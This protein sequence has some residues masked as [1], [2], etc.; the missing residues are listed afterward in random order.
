MRSL[1]PPVIARRLWQILAGYGLIVTVIYAVLSSSTVAT[2]GFLS[3][4]VLTVAACFSGPRTWGAEPPAAW[5]LIGSAASLFL[6]GLLIRPVVTDYAMPWPLLADLC[7]FSGYV[8]IGSF[9]IVMLRRRESTERHAVLDGLIAMLSTGLT[10]VLLLAL[11]AAAITGR[12][13]VVSIVQACYPICDVV[14]AMLV[15]NL[16]FTTRTWPVS[17]VA[18]LTVMVGMFTGDTL[19]AIAG[20]GGKIYASPLLDLPYLVAYTALGISAIHPSVVEIS[21]AARPPVQAWSGWRMALLIPAMMTPFLLMLSHSAEPFRHRVLL[22]A[23]G[24]VM[25]VLLVLRAV[26]AVQAQVEAQLHSEH[27]ASHDPLTSLPNRQA[28]S[29]AIEQVVLSVDPLGPDRVWVYM[30]DLDGFKWVND[31]WGHD[32]GDQLVIEVGRRLRAAVPDEIPVARVGGDE[33]LL[34]YVGDKAGALRLVDDIR[35]CFA[36]PLPVR[37]TEVVISASIGIA[38]SSGDAVRSAVTAEALMRDAD[39]AMYRAKSEGPGRS[40]IFDTSMHDQ[41]RERIELEVMLRQALAEDQ[42]HVAYQ[43]IVRLETG[44]PVGAEAL[45]R[46]MHP[47]RGA[48]P[49]MTFIPIA[50]DAGLI[51]QIGTWVRNEALRQL[52]EWRRAGIVSEAFYLSINVSPRQLSEPELPL[53]V[54]GEMLKYGVPPASVALEMTESVMVDGSSVTARV[55]FE[56]RELGVKLLVDDFGTGF[57]ALGYL[58]RFPVTGVKIDRSFVTGLGVNVEDDEI[59][60]AVVAMSHA[61]GLS[62]IAEGVETTVQREALHQVGVVNGQGW[63]WGKAETAEVFA[64]QWHLEAEPPDIPLP[65]SS[66]THGRHHRPGEPG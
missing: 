29:G 53:I 44:V 38:H 48:I 26:S 28:I 5:L 65:V 10:V 17:M 66:V 3:L 2:A 11:P 49:P 59:V 20:V 47:E 21:R 50:E 58:R 43:P 14:L 18:L 57:S 33:F 7:T 40:T 25:V 41:V 8:L 60:R 15:V 45:V 9:F 31:S 35:G 56:L 39:T 16:A 63:L 51:G 24:S 37:D 55:L 19:Y 34:A 64:E 4:G 32:T 42:L 27:Q 6:V 22:A 1:L 12:S 30:L 54:S 62:V 46:W 13:P 61:L 52:G 36:R 23:I